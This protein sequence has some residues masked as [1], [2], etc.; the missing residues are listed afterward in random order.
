M[1]EAERRVWVWWSTGKDSAWTLRTL[2]ADPSVEV[3]GLVTTITPTFG[4]VSIHGTRVELLEAQASRVG[5]PLRTIG[6]PYPCPNDAYEA[7][8]RPML[9]DARDAGVTHLAAGDL[10]LEDVRAYREGLL[11]G[12]GVHPLF[13]IW[14]T[15]T[16]ELAAAMIDEGVEAY[17]TCLDPGRLDAGWAGARF[18]HA[19][20]EALPAD[21]DPC[22]ERGEF[23][24]CVVAGPGFDRAVPVRGGRVVERDGSVFADLLLDASAD[25]DAGS[26][27]DGDR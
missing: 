21:V 14:G 5:L 22:G 10:F 1:S 25:E 9:Q 15:D 19:F 26:A 27:P 4:R 12:S 13:P 6:L 20:L 7:A 18:D 23:H 8:V 3:T 24:T 11:E 17:V 16:A 2:R